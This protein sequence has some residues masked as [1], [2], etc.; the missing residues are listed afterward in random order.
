VADDSHIVSL[1]TN[2]R[3]RSFGWLYARFTVSYRD[4]EEPLGERDL[5]VSSER[6]QR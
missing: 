1:V 5:D 6:Q 3:R 2:T 4:A